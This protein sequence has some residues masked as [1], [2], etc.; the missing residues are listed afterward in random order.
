MLS[1]AE[2]RKK[3]DDGK[4]DPAIII[5]VFMKCSVCVLLLVLLL[6]IGVQSPETTLDDARLAAGSIQQRVPNSF[7]AK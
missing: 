5:G 7:Y 3:F 2:K 1:A 4:H 6:L